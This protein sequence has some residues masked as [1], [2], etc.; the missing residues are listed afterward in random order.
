MPR[1]VVELLPSIPVAS[2]ATDRGLMSA[3]HATV[4]L[5][6]TP[7]KT[8][9]HSAMPGEA[10]RTDTAAAAFAV[11]L[12]RNPPDGCLVAVEDATASWASHPL[13]VVT[14]DGAKINGGSGAVGVS[15]NIN[16]ASRMFRYDSAFDN[17]RRLSGGADPPPAQTFDGGFAP[18]P[19][20]VTFDNWNNAGWP[21]GPIPETPTDGIEIADFRQFVQ[22]YVGTLGQEP[23]YHDNPV[24]ANGADDSDGAVQIRL[25]AGPGAW[26]AAGGSVTTTYGRWS[27][28]A[29][30]LHLSYRP[31]PQTPGG[32]GSDDVDTLA[33]YR[34][35][36]DGGA[37]WSPPATLRMTLVK[38]PSAVIFVDDYSMVFNNLGADNTTALANAIAAAAA[39]G[40]TLT[41]RS[42]A[43]WAIWPN[44]P[45]LVVGA[46]P[47]TTMHVYAIYGRMEVATKL[48]PTGSFQVG[49]ASN[50][51]FSI[52]LPDVALAPYQF[53]FVDFNGRSGAQWQPDGTGIWDHLP[54][55]PEQQAFLL[56]GSN[57]ATDDATVTNMPTARV[58]YSMFYNWGS[59]VLHVWQNADLQTQYCDYI[60][61]FRGSSTNVASNVKW[62]VQDCRHAALFTNEGGFML[63]SFLYSE[64]TRGYSKAEYRIERVILDHSISMNTHHH[65]EEG[66]LEDCDLQMNDVWMSLDYG[67]NVQLGPGMKVNRGRLVASTTSSGILR[68]G[69]N[70][71][72]GRREIRDCQIIINN[73]PVV[74]GNVLETVATTDEIGVGLNWWT[75]NFDPWP[76]GWT[77]VVA[78][79][80]IRISAGLGGHTGPI[81]GF[82]LVSMEESEPPSTLRLKNVTF[83]EAA[84]GKHFTYALEGL[85]TAPLRVEYDAATAAK[86]AALIAAGRFWGPNTTPLLLPASPVRRGVV[87]ELRPGGQGHLRRLQ[88]RAVARAGATR[89]PAVRRLDHLEGDCERRDH[90]RADDSERY[91]RRHVYAGRLGHQLRRWQRRPAGVM[92]D[93]VDRR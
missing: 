67:G 45:G 92:G 39:G 46:N 29:D 7:L 68:F 52:Q 62:Y 81:Y 71:P 90:Q 9:A 22:M 31:K 23:L 63:K 15:F 34:A 36:L 24:T 70:T 82:K 17:W 4:A 91:G 1:S 77:D 27:V 10:V 89:R 72:G 73:K 41:Q 79:T 87:F 25:A 3:A 28:N 54:I 78:N 58:K 69:W 60:G 55:G 76:Y 83:A 8:G 32:P 56:F 43:N 64:P 59:M 88:A 93:P 38:P 65:A 48:D 16:G 42:G 53:L 21:R 85:A 5:V 75:F 74:G 11:T 14:T 61:T 35:S 2:P 12:P 18:V 30:G 86:N 20:D 47:Q 37:S 50:R 44:P 49:D 57:N 33:Q 51:V 26:Q 40:L 66:W 6:A 19:Q 13:L 80:E 84:D